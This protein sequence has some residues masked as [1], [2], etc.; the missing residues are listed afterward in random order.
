MCFNFIE[1]V[2]VYVPKLISFHEK[3][4]EDEANPKT[5]NLFSLQYNCATDD[6]RERLDT[7]ILRVLYHAKVSLHHLNSQLLLLVNPTC[8]SYVRE[9]RPASRLSADMIQSLYMYIKESFF[10][11]YSDFST[12]VYNISP[13]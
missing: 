11:K 4:H 5:V 3:S 2:C 9:R 6:E 12:Y 7:V 1:I 13:V 8:M 10:Y